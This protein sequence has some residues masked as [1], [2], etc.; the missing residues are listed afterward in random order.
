MGRRFCGRCGHAL[1]PGVHF[2]GV[3]G[4]SVPDSAGQDAARSQVA[5]EGSAEDARAGPQQPDLPA[6]AHTITATPVRPVPPLSAGWGEDRGRDAVLP[7]AADQPVF[8]VGSPPSVQRPPGAKPPG[9]AAPARRPRRPAVGRPLAVALAVLVVAGGTAAGLLLTRHP[10]HS[11]LSASQSQVSPQGRSTL[12][13]S[14][15]PS[16]APSATGTTTAPSPPPAPPTQMSSQGVTIGIGAV[17]TDADAVNVARTL[18]AYFG[19][20]NTRNYTQAWNTLTPSM[21][22][23]LSL[24]YF[25]SQESTSRDSQVVVHSLHHDSN[26]DIGAEVT[27]QSH[28]AGQ[29]GPDLGD[30]CDNWSLDYEL[31]PSAS[32]GA[33]SYLIN[34]VETVGTGHVSC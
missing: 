3:C 34:K 18:A 16:T 22:V 21:K 26:G 27:F 15:T 14:A 7:G 24:Q 6:Y 5:A 25:S 17:N 23:G 2:C 9:R 19:G 1:K 13:P 30:T 4:H 28:Q 31:V 20:I 29:Y 32:S 8:R 10:A 11:R 33:L 12:V